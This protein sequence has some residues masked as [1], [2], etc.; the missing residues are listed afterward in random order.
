MVELGSILEVEV[1]VDGRCKLLIRFG[2]GFGSW[3]S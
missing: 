3:V 1:V 2:G